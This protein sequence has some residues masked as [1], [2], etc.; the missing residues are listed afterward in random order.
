MGI[1]VHREC[2]HGIGLMFSATRR[3][4]TQFFFQFVTFCSRCLISFSNSFCWYFS[5]CLVI[6]MVLFH[7]M[8]NE[9]FV[10]NT[11]SV[12]VLFNDWDSAVVASFSL[13]ASC[14]CSF[15]NRTRALAAVTLSSAA[16]ILPSI[17]PLSSRA[18]SAKLTLNVQYLC[19]MGPLSILLVINNFDGCLHLT[20]IVVTFL[21]MKIWSC[22]FCFLWGIQMQR[23]ITKRLR[24]WYRQTRVCVLIVGVPFLLA[25]TSNLTERVDWYKECSVGALITEWLW[26]LVDYQRIFD[27]GLFV[28]RLMQLSVAMN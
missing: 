21:G 14:N 19:R 25:L 28:T 11:R 2:Y 23:K 26:E 1:K 16:S 13:L 9:S 27:R 18:V 15:L 24:Q 5:F 4:V 8:T 12:I 20:M 22:W 6:S 3:S 17:G 7:I 10:L